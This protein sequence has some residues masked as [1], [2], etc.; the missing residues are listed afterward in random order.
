M[1]I[2]MVWKETTLAIL[3]V[4]AFQNQISSPLPHGYFKL[5]FGRNICN[6]NIGVAGCIVAKT[7]MLQY[8]FFSYKIVFYFSL[9]FS[10]GYRIKI[11]MD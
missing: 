2:N 9:Q 4:L 10:S 3:L 11:L 6:H 8:I 7:E 1:T 5:L